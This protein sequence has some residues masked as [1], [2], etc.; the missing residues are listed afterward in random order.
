MQSQTQDSAIIA[1]HSSRLQLSTNLT[2]ASHNNDRN[3]ELLNIQSY[4][5]TQKKWT[6]HITELVFDHKK[7]E[8]HTFQHQHQQQNKTRVFIP[9]II[10]IEMRN[11]P[12]RSPSNALQGP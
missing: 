6:I 5:T 4:N 7:K 1:M 8:K 9:N 11:L 10:L 3:I 12:V 2:L